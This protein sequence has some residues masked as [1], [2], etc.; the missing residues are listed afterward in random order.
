MDKFRI[1]VKS[2]ETAD[3]MLILSDQLDL[4]SEEEIAIL[5]AELASRNDEPSETDYEQFR[6]I[7]E[8]E[9][10]K[11]AAIER[12][13]ILENA[14][15]MREAQERRNREE[16]ER[17]EKERRK[18]SEEKIRSLKEKG[19]DGYFEYRTLELTDGNGDRIS[20]AKVSDSLNDLALDGWRL[21]SAYSNPV[22]YPD[23]SGGFFRQ[24]TNQQVMILERYVKF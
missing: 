13:R 12:Q 17:R 21:V 1:E 10:E 3:I 14:R 4:Y 22:G 9:A 18:I 6:R 16:K 8:A 23:Q 2:Y 19:H 24:I 20:A 11:A 15:I 5:R 7:E